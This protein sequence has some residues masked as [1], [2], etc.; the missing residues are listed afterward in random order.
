LRRK[1]DEESG[2]ALIDLGAATQAST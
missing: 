1:H 2:L